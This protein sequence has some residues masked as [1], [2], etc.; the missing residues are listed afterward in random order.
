MRR[1]IVPTRMIR[2][3]LSSSKTMRHAPTRR[4][5]TSS[6]PRRRI[7]SPWKGSDSRSPSAASNR[8]RSRRGARPTALL[9]SGDSLTSQPTAQ[10]VEGDELAP[11]DL[12]DAAPEGATLRWAQHVL[13]LFAPPCAARR[14]RARIAGWRQSPDGHVRNSSEEQPIAFYHR[15]GKARAFHA[16]GIAAESARF[17]TAPPSA[18]EE[19]AAPLPAWARRFRTGARL[20]RDSP[21]PSRVMARS[22]RPASAPGAGPPAKRPPGPASSACATCRWGGRKAISRSWRCNA[23]CR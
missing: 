3:G 11:F 1:T 7:A 13:G 16:A 20:R 9:A 6:L 23:Q 12:G 8:G 19:T 4:L 10:L 15:V 21:S 17:G 2:F 18:V 22:S 14:E 5:Q